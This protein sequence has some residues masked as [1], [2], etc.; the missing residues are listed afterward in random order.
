MR[1][2][3]LVF[4]TVIKQLGYRRFFP[5]LFFVTL[6]EAKSLTERALALR[7]FAPVTGTQTCPR[8]K[9]RNDRKTEGGAQ[10]DSMLGRASRPV[11]ERSQGNNIACHS[12][13]RAGKM[14]SLNSMR[15][16]TCDFNLEQQDVAS[17]KQGNQNNEWVESVVS[18]I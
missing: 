4:I 16:K 11:L 1:C 17:T 14:K 5:S 18:R 9:R 10:N 12:E 3:V 6:S 2:L 15:I 7:F 8:A 13:S